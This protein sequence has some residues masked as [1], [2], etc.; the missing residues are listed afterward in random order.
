MS[1]AWSPCIYQWLQKCQWLIPHHYFGPR[2]NNTD[3]LPSWNQTDEKCRRQMMLAGIN[4]Q[5]ANSYRVTNPL[6]NP[7]GLIFEL[8]LFHWVVSTLWF[9]FSVIFKTILHSQVSELNYLYSELSMLLVQTHKSAEP[10]PHLVSDFPKLVWVCTTD[11]AITSNSFHSPDFSSPC[12]PHL[13]TSLAELSGSSCI[14]KHPQA[15]S[16]ILGDATHAHKIMP[17]KTAGCDTVLMIFQTFWTDHRPPKIKSQG[18]HQCPLQTRDR[19]LGKQGEAEGTSLQH[20][21]HKLHFTPWHTG[22][23]SFP[24]EETFHTGDETCVTDLIFV[25]YSLVNLPNLQMFCVALLLHYLSIFSFA[26]SVPS[27]ITLGNQTFAI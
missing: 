16:Q 9:F 24:G 18:Y 14:L 10:Q 25:H 23:E 17:T 7:T 2:R 6:Y 19:S 4:A 13:N 11:T 15:L 20:C 8:V 27:H 22:C 12:H 3:D 1:H 26:L 5:P 21:W